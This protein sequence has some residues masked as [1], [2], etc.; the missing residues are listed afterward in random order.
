M[1]V[2]ING[3]L[4]N[5]AEARISPLDHGLLTGDGVFESVRVSS[6]RPFALGRHLS[7]LARSASGLGISCPDA[8]T[9]RAACAEVVAANRLELGKLRITVTAG[10]APLS[11][12][13]GEGPP[14]VVVAGSPLSPW[15]PVADVVVVPWRRNEQGAMAG[16]KSISYA[17]NVRALAEAR[18]AGAD[19]AI[20][21]NTA[22]RLCEGTGTNVFVGTMDRLLTPPLTSGCLAGVTRELLLEAGV[23]EEADL[24]LDA[25]GQADE[26]FLSST[27]RVVQPI[28]AVDGT[29]LP[30]VPGPLTKKAA[31]VMAELEERER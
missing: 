14:T 16:I 26:A 5:E 30:A 11:S 24:A 15:S 29:A 13:R 6:G 1:L 17:E 12:E 19:E 31:Q 21:A 9:L 22:G 3:R 18:K 23:A 4:M 2:W 20:F 27:T 8:A 10:P 28:R 25:L 7:R